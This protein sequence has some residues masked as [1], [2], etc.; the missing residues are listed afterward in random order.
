[1]IKMKFSFINQYFVLL[2]GTYLSSTENPKN[3]KIWYLSTFKNVNVK[4]N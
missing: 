3:L 1:M 4:I 2:Q